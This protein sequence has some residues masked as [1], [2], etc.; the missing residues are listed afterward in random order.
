[1]GASTEEQLIQKEREIEATRARLSQDT[2]ELGDKLSPQRM[3]QR[4]TEAAKGRMSS[5]RERVMGTTSGVSGAADSVG[6]SVHTG[7]H[8]VQS[9]TEGNPLTAGLVAFGAGMVLSAV[10]PA[11]Q[12]ER[13]VGRAAVDTARDH[14]QPLIDEA[15][16]AGADVAENMKAQV[17]GAGEELRATAQDAAATVKDEARSSAE[18]VKDEAQQSGSRGSAGPVT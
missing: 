2:D 8:R 18:N 10:F 6:D 13:L 5:L 7:T 17:A 15:K 1:M 3:V 11:T 12:K 16:S 4:R 14:G 9:A